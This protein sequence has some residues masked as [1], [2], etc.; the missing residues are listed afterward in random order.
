M[1][2]EAI[3]KIEEGNTDAILD[4]KKEEI[5]PKEEQAS[6]TPDEI[7]NDIVEKCRF[8]GINSFQIIMLFVSVLQKAGKNM[9]CNLIQAYISMLVAYLVMDNKVK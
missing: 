9:E 1:K 6:K 5:I 2:N 8:H 7:F 3:A 4:S